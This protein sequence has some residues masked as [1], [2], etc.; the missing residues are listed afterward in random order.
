M[1]QWLLKQLED[2]PAVSLLDKNLSDL[3]LTSTIQEALVI[4]TSY[5]HRPRS[6]LVVKKNL[7]QAQRLYERISSFLEDDECALFASD[8]SLRVEA[9]ASSPEMS[10]IKVETMSSLL[11]NPHQVAH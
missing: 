4:A 3:P 2:N 1:P 7:Y 6:I 9:I 10:A 5:K 8:E 11:E